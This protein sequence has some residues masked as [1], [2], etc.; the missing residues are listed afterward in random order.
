MTELL[1]ASRRGGSARTLSCVVLAV[2]ALLSLSACGL[3]GGPLSGQ[4][5]EEGTRKPVPGAIVVAKWEGNVWAFVETRL[6]CVHVES[7][8]ADQEGRYKLP[9]WSKPSTVGPVVMDL[10]PVVVAYK[11]GY[12]LPSEPSQEQEIELIAPFKGRVKERFEYLDRVI[13]STSC[14]SAGSSYRNLYRIRSAIYQEAR[15]I[16][17]TLEEKRY[18]ETYEELVER[19]LVDRTKPTKYDERGR[20]INV[21]PEDS[22]KP[23]GLR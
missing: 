9:R 1:S 10:A 7:T 8:I 23:E 5:L 20:L 18:A 21:N 4:V 12:G 22:L 3:S 17:Q 6:V 11:P 2:M 13:S 19:I 15:S 16:A 14:V